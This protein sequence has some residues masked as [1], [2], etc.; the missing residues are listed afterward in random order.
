MTSSSAYKKSAHIVGDV[1]EALIGTLPFTMRWY[2]WLNHWLS[3]L[4]VDGHGNFGSIDGDGAAAMRYTEARMSKLR[5]KWFV[6]SIKI[7]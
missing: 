7:P 2:V 6:T 4:L 3:F 1:I 5:W